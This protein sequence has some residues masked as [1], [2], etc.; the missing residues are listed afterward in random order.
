MYTSFTC[1]DY[2]ETSAPSPSPQLATN[3]PT[4]SL[5]GQKTGRPETVPTFAKESIDQVGNPALSRQH[6]H[7]YAA[8]FHRG[9][10]TG[11]INR[12]RS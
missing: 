4:S 12:L 11:T 10:L 2:Y 9:L 7:A 1:P 8:D 3:L 5:A 6:R